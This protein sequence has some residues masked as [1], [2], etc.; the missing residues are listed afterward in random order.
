MTTQNFEAAARAP[1]A[2]KLLARLLVPEVLLLVL[3][4]ALSLACALMFPEQ[5]A[6]VAL[7]F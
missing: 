2:A 5:M 6:D 7:R 1:V 4:A 3:L